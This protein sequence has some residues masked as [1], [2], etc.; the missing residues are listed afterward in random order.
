MVYDANYW[1]TKWTRA[2]I[3]YTGRALR[4]QSAQIGADVKNFIMTN[5]VI[6]QEIIKQYGLK[7]TTMNDTALA[8]QRWVVQFLFYKEDD[9]ANKCPE[10]WQPLW[11]PGYGSSFGLRR[12]VH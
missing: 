6:L 2:P 10:F 9:A 11:L 7:K 12:P 4:G 5:D 8:C 3:V 1:N